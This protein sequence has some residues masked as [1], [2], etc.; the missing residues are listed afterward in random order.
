MQIFDPSNEMA[1][2]GNS[3]D[4]EVYSDI[5]SFLMFLWVQWDRELVQK[6]GGSLCVV[7]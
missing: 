1:L 3:Q 6:N 7:V 4:F 5:F 2:H